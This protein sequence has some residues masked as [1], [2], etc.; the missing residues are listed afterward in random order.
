MILVRS[1]RHCCPKDHQQH[2]ELAAWQPQI[3]VGYTQDH[4]D[5]D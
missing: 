5:L 3:A 4:H 1:P 2:F